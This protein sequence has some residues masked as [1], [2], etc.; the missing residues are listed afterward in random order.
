MVGLQKH[1][2]DHGRAA[3]ILSITWKTSSDDQASTPTFKCVLAGS[4]AR[5]VVIDRESASMSSVD[6]AP[7]G[8]TGFRRPEAA[9]R[10][11]D[12]PAWTPPRRRPA[13]AEIESQQLRRPVHGQEEASV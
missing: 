9:K 1:H 3:L 10:L 5:R 2:A 4:T 12:A 7:W 8:L 11:G 13:P 6:V